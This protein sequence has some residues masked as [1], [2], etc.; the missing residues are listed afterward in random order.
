MRPEKSIIV[1]H[2]QSIL[3]ESGNF[4]LVSYT[5]LS[6]QKQEE[7]KGLLREQNAQFQVHKNKLIKKAAEGKSYA[8]VSEMKLEGG[9]ALVYGEGETSEWAKVVKK[10]AKDNEE[11]AFKGAFFDGELLDAAKAKQVA[12]LPSK[13]EAR[14]LVLSALMA[15]P[16]KL[17][18][19]LN[20]VVAGVP[21]VIKNHCDKQNE[22]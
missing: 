20:Q 1:E 7:L 17:A 3:D 11:V 22:S 15:G 18:G 4:L 5:G 6:V 9:T 2:I 12:E 13:D 21:S 19:I 16:Q 14:A 8:A 10:F